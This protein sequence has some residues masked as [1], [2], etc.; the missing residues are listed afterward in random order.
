MYAGEALIKLAVMKFVSDCPAPASPPRIILQRRT[1]K[2]RVWCI[3]IW[4]DIR[5]SH[6][7]GLCM[8]ANDRL[9]TET[10]QEKWRYRIDM[11]LLIQITDTHI[12][13]PG[14]ILYGSIDSALH[15]EQTVQQ[16]N[17][18][19][20]LPDAVIFTGDLVERG[21]AA[22]YE[23][24]IRLI[25]PLTMPA[26]VLPGNH[27]DPAV[28][29]KT[30][31]GTP[32]FPAFDATYQYVIEDLPFRILALNSYAAGTELPAFD[33]RRLEWL[34]MQLEQSDRPTLLAIHHPPMITGIELIDMGGAE[35]YQ[36]LKSL[37]AAHKQVR[38]V[39]CGH[40]HTDLTGRIGQVP[41]YMA[42]ANSHQLIATRGLK[43]AP[44]TANRPGPPTPHHY[45]EGEF[46]SGAQVWPDDVDDQRIDIK[47]GLS[48][49][50]LKT[51]MMGSRAG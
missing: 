14:E 43:I 7:A 50:E 13:P 32:C 30:F 10:R 2:G 16:V 19:R 25:E 27:D 51:K 5:N 18:M 45:I 11:T 40:C 33:A 35:W 47:S 39:I 37:I 49:A 28:M 42:P 17:R 15:L 9:A 34:R 21:D 4:A 22:G 29:L 1:L 31:A 20:P 44:A 46:L 26:W 48:W 23:H 24:F 38:L 3:F 8:S 12:L 6:K 41:V 36:G